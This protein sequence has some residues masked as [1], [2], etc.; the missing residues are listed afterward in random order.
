MKVIRK[1]REFLEDTL[2]VSDFAILQGGKRA[3]KSVALWQ[4]LYENLLRSKKKAIILTDTYSRLRDSVIS[5]FQMITAENPRLTKIT[6]GTGAYSI[7]F[8]NGSEINFVCSEKDTRGFTSNNDYIVCNEANMYEWGK[9]NDLLKAGGE[10]CKVIFDYN[11][12][13]RFYVQDYYEKAGNKLITTYNDNPFIP[14]FAKSQLDEQ[15]ERGKSAA[16]GTMDRYLYE[17]ECLGID[18]NLSGLCFPNAE[19]IPEK[20]Y[21]DFEATEILCSDW[22]Q[23]GATAD[24]DVVIGIKIFGNKI[25]IHEYFYDNSSTDN[26]IYQVLDKSVPKKSQFFVYETAT[27]GLSRINNL[28]A[29]GLRFRF[30]PA[31]KPPLMYSIREMKDYTLCITDTSLNVRFEQQN[32][33]FINVKGILQPADKNNHA[34]DALRYGYFYKKNN[35]LL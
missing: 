12:Y 17:V 29:M 30:V 19:Y 28:Y 9:V 23:S 26:D 20:E 6:R 2:N 27:Q 33:N 22:G 31:Q 35:N 14:K 4:F 18:S 3:G 24:P 10:N 1:Y 15:T 8:Y 25:L 34:L 5:D 13:T 32:Y 16:I 21:F 11:P 7:R